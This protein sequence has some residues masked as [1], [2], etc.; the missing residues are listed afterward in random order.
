[1]VCF[2]LC[3]I[4]AEMLQEV[5]RLAVAREAAA[6]E[7]ARGRLATWAA[8]SAEAHRCE[9][10]VPRDVPTERYRLAPRRA[11]KP[12]P[13]LRGRLC[14]DLG[15]P[16]SS[17]ARQRRAQPHAGQ[18][19][20]RLSEGKS[21]GR[22]RANLHAA[23]R[24]LRCDGDTSGEER[25]CTCSASLNEL[26][27]SIASKN[28]VHF[29]QPDYTATTRSD[30]TSGRRSADWKEANPTSRPGGFFLWLFFTTARL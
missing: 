25:S 21:A 29:C 18:D 22:C 5:A 13:E 23:S 3:E 19:G 4:P 16:A 15:Q 17:A 30:Y 10:Y 7:I 1:M 12:G 28:L 8:A 6:A 11:M 26:V 27:C 24:F 14:S 20:V 2:L 9:P